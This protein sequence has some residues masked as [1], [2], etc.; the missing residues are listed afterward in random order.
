MAWTWLTNVTD[1]TYWESPYDY[2]FDSLIWTGSAWAS[3]SSGLFPC[4]LRPKGAY[5]DEYYGYAEDSGILSGALIR[6]IKVYGTLIESPYTYEVSVDV[7]TT[8]GQE[9][10]TGYFTTSPFMYETSWSP[11][12]GEGVLYIRLGQFGYWYEPGL[13]TRIDVEI[14]EADPPEDPEPVAVW[15][16]YRNC[17]EIVV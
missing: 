7:R 12:P 9:T 16:G 11:A 1:D 5:Y 14:W 13:I 4:V 10:T 15:T 6:A 8:E 3:D 2:Y 17:R